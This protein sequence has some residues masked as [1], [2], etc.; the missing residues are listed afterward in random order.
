MTF[1]HRYML[2]QV[3]TKLSCLILDTPLIHF[4]YLFIVYFIGFYVLLLHVSGSSSLRE[5]IRAPLQSKLSTKMK[6]NSNYTPLFSMVSSHLHFVYSAIIFRIITVFPVLQIWHFLKLK[7]VIRYHGQI[8]CLILFRWCLCLRNNRQ[9]WEHSMW[10]SL[11]C[12]INVPSRDFNGR[13]Q[14]QAIKNVLISGEEA[15][16][17]RNGTSTIQLKDFGKRSKYT[18]NGTS[19]IN[20]LVVSSTSNPQMYCT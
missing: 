20:S 19:K 3:G 1:F 4:I 17:Y 5:P 15:D 7:Q 8:L 11:N 18:K 10:Y 13:I 9:L 12:S 6:L 2:S 14:I 16:E